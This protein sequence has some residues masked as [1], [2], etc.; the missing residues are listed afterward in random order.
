MYHLTGKEPLIARI[1]AAVGYTGR[2]FKLE[3]KSEV[4]IS[5]IDCMWSGGSRATWYAISFPDFA[6][7]DPSP[8]C[9][10]PNPPVNHT[11]A[12]APGAG[13]LVRHSIF[14]G[15]DSGLTI[16][17][18]PDGLA[19]MLP[20]ASG[21][22]PSQAELI[23]LVATAGLKP[24]HAGISNCRFHEAHERTGISLE[25][26]EAAKAS[27]I[28]KGLLNRA[29]AITPAGRNA[30]ERYSVGLCKWPKL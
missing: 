2:K 21:S 30:C 3:P 20:A 19:K 26:W 17:V 24:S 15:K 12:L 22:A 10:F 14:C 18:H 6:V 8:P 16:Y 5:G 29:G 23:V 11:V 4:G 1:A 25:Q 28:A 27:C 7:A 13:I 9:T